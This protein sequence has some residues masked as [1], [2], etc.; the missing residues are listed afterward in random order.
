M[1]GIGSISK[2]AS[3]RNRYSGH[4][5]ISQKRSNLLCISKWTSYRP[6]IHAYSFIGFAEK[7]KLEAKIGLIEL[8]YGN[9][10]VILCSPHEFMGEIQEM[11]DLIQDRTHM[12]KTSNKCL[13][14]FL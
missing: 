11:L 1:H 12:H 4:T 9:V 8:S 2:L 7:E 5:I 3:T 14:L 13:Q 10:A 6:K